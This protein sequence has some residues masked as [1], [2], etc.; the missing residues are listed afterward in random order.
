MSREPASSSETTVRLV[1]LR[2]RD[3]VEIDGLRY[4]D[5]GPSPIGVLHVHGKG[6]SF[7]TGPSRFVPPRWPGVT[8]LALNMRFRDLAFTDAEGSPWASAG[9]VPAGGGFWER[10]ADGPHDL[11][12][13]VEHLRAFGCRHVV[14]VGHSSGG[15]YTARYA[16][17]DPG[18]AARVLIGPLTGNRTAFHRWFGSDEKRDIAIE[19]AEAMVA[20]GRGHELIP[21]STWYYAVSA[22]SLLERASEPDGVWID[23]VNAN[24]SPTLLVW[25]GLEDRD[26]L[27]R[28]L[29]EEFAMEHKELAVVDGAEHH[30][31]RFEDELV[32][33]IRTFVDGL[34]LA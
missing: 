6:S 22:T 23:A 8:H 24:P 31:V 3:G 5:G 4:D 1:R 28:Q 29:F 21:L 12:A 14:I 17:E 32:E 25:G 7:L 34:G 27:W 10:I 15:F 33:I 19:R 20:D 18:I 30:F 13:G 11:A 26:A 16:A 9:A 2:A